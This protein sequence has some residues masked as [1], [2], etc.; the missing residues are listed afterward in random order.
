M[1]FYN[2][3]DF[4]T[5][6]SNQDIHCTDFTCFGSYNRGDVITRLNVNSSIINSILIHKVQGKH[7]FLRNLI[8]FNVYK[9]KDICIRLVY[10]ANI[11]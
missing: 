6:R 10:F 1:R 3:A 9:A 2:V 7:Y 5:S 4:Y 11:P 8:V